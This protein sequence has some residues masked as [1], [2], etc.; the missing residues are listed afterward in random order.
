MG[1][2]ALAGIIVAAVVLVAAIAFFVVVWL[3]GNNAV[4]A[5]NSKDYEKAYNS[6]KMALFLDEGSK[7]LILE[8]Y[9]T[10]TL[11]VEGKYYTAAKLLEESTIA[12]SKKEKIYADNNNLA[13]CKKGAVAEFA[14]WEQDGDFANGKEAIEWLILD[15]VEENG[16]AKAL[17]MST[18]V[19]GNSDGWNQWDNKNCAYAN[20]GLHSWCEV[21]FYKTL[22]ADSEV[23]KVIL[24]T[25]V[26]TADSSTGIDS[27]EDV[28]AYVFAPSKQD[29][30]KYLTGDLAKYVTAEGTK[31]V[32]DSGVTLNGEGAASY[33]LRNAG[34]DTNTISAVSRTGEVLEDASK[35]GQI[36]VRVCL[37]IDLGEI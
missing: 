32:K 19:I 12:D 28:E 5:Y 20:S 36:G 7:N 37:W 11:C 6:T 2:G 29:I 24:K 21:D 35:D 30:E 3:A 26:S 4:T 17:L 27:G 14:T 22:M 13:L 34:K 10:K 33:F 16:R 23:K 1:K 31:A 18:K 9:I 15:V 8:K 25:T